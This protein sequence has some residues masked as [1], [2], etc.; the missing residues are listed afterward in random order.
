MFV[1]MMKGIMT[2]EFTTSIN[3]FLFEKDDI[4]SLKRHHFKR[5]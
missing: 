1:Q 5:K 2:T 4:M 3:V